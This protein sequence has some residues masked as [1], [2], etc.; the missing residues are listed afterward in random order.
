MR[1]CVRA[2]TRACACACVRACVCV[3]AA[4]RAHGR[5]GAGAHRVRS[6][7]ARCSRV[8]AQFVVRDGLVQR[9]ACWDPSSTLLHAAVCAVMDCCV[10]YCS[11]VNIFVCTR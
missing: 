9:A 8:L 6:F 3:F 5:A 1:A 10:N 7:C 11:V 4:S 2:R